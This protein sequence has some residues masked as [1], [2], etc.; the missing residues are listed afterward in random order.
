MATNVNTGDPAPNEPFASRKRLRRDKFIGSSARVIVT[1]PK[2]A[3]AQ[4]ERRTP[5]IGMGGVPTQERRY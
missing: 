4:T 3:P 5:S 2:A 1:N